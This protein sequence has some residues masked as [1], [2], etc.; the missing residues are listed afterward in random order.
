MALLF[1]GRDLPIG[2]VPTKASNDSNLM[3]KLGCFN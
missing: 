2:Q 1:V 3:N